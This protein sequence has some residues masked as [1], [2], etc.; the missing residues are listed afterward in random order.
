MVG[1]ACVLIPLSREVAL[2]TPN[3]DKY[4]VILNVL[5]A[6]GLALSLYALVSGLRAWTSPHRPITKVKFTLVALACL[7]L[8]WFAISFHLIGQVTRL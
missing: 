2:P 7:V 5:I 8:C 3:W 1:I 6:I 4:F